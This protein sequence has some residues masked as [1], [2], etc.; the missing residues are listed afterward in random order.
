MATTTEQAFAALFELVQEAA[1]FRATTRDVRQWSAL[2][3]GVLPALI[4][5]QTS[6]SFDSKPNIPTI[7]RL[8]ADLAIICDASDSVAVPSTALNA[9]VD[10][11]L[12]ALAPD[13]IT[14]M[15]QTLGGLVYDCKPMGDGFYR[16]ATTPS[17]KSYALIRVEILL[18]M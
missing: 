7:V 15:R 6:P 3:S 11:V 1:P 9:V 12:A 5:E 4:Q 10:A 2:E 17:S 8:K 18:T 16:E 13:P 14:D